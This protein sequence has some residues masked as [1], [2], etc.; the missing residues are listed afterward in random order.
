MNEEDELRKLG[1]EPP[2][3][4]STLSKQE[5]EA[6]A[7][8]KKQQLSNDVDLDF[9]YIENGELK[10]SEPEVKVTKEM[11]L[12]RYEHDL[13][14][15]DSVSKRRVLDRE[16]L[17]FEWKRYIDPE[18]RSAKLELLP[19]ALND[20]CSDW[21]VKSEKANLILSGST[22]V[23]K[24]YT[25]HAVARE[26]YTSGKIVKI[27]NLVEMLDALRPG[28]NPLITLTEI[29]KAPYLLLDDFGAEKGSTWVEERMF[30]IF[31]YRWRFKLPTIITTNISP[32]NFFG[33]FGKRV[34]SRL[35]HK[36]TIYVI[37]GKDKRID[38]S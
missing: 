27:F 18:F 23:G 19:D 14:E 30:A 37:T 5:L 11:L 22:G 29:Q 24:S 31:D 26:L 35:V 13:K 25:A 12:A 38:K 17:E 3:D 15:Q 32:K 34:A 28:G 1:L 7:E 36:S 2:V 4:L 9:S 33:A 21:L 20:V 10:D 8:E 16:F 6:I